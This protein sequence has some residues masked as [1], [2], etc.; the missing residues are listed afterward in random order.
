[1]D[2]ENERNSSDSGT[3]IQ[4]AE[5]LQH[6]LNENQPEAAL[7]LV[8]DEDNQQSL[9]ND[10]SE[11]IATVVKFLTNE[12]FIQNAK[13]YN[14]SEEILKSIAGKAN[15]GEVVLELLEVIDTTKNDNTVVSILKALQMCLLRQR[16]RRVRSLE[17]CLNS[18]QLYVS[19][20]PLSA[21]LRQ[22]MDTEEEK[23][24]EEDDEVRRIISFYFYLFLFY[25]PILDHIMIDSPPN[26]TYFR[27]CGITRRNVL[28]CFIIQL[29]NEPFAIF[30]LSLP[31][32][33]EHNGEMTKTNS[34]SYTRQCATTLIKHIS[35]LIPDPFQL[36]AYG[37]R[38]VRWPY[39][40]PENDESIMNAPPLADIFHIEEK[41][42]LTALAVMFYAM[43]AEDLIPAKAP[44][45]YRNCYLF[46]MG[47]YYVTELLSSTEDALHTKG[48]RLA[49]KLLEN[50]GS[51]QLT[52]ETLDLEVHTTFL[53]N[54]ISMLNVTQVRRNSKYG[55]ELLKIYIMKFQTTQAQHFYI[56]RLLQTVQN[57]K[58]CGYLVTIY[59][60]IVADQLTA[61]N[62][63]N[64]EHRLFEISPYCS[65]TELQTL[66]LEHICV[67]PQGAETDILQYNDLILAAL[68]M[69]RFLAIRD[70]HNY[71]QIWNFTDQIQEKFLKPLREALDCSRAH[72]RLEEKRIQQ[73]NSPEIECDISSSNSSDFMAMTKENRLQVLTIGQNTFDLIESLMSR[74][75]EC[76]EMREKK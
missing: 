25:E 26:E 54:L 30:D 18:I 29:F 32:A 53:G 75:I 49:T 36:M 68:N 65:G 48:I 37:E 3:T 40:L 57:N 17:W 6:L 1:M 62:M 44:K 43:I 33:S 9:I 19:D 16:E 31:T 73:K 74:L 10:C 61:M 41:A 67:I 8:N 38:R 35:T 4:L 2:A 45:I 15:E 24:L 23:F 60:N 59:K 72:Y 13:L 64:D 5:H 42:P 52:D 28:A 71:T 55:I 76:I 69:L 21:E 56:R 66:L 51:E 11:S 12:N 27:N 58:I 47:L 50:F 70:T 20:L 22:R 7:A 63:A 39:I 34:N 14:G 46:E